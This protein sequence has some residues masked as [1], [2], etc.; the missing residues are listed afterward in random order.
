MHGYRD[1][2]E[3]YQKA[4]SKPFLRD[5]RVPT[6]LVNAQNDP[7]LT[8]ECFPLEEATDNPNL[9]LEM[10]GYGGHVGFI[11]PGGDN[12]YWSEKRVASFMRETLHLD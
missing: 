7:F 8:P 6:L 12:V 9:W 11:L 10:P 2:T 1:G 4:S 3:Y 5:I